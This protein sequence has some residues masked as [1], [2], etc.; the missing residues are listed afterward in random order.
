LRGGILIDEVE[1]KGLYSAEAG[2]VMQRA[3]RIGKVNVR[4][5]KRSLGRGTAE[6]RM[7]E[8]LRGGSLTD[9]TAID[10]S[11]RQFG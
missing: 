8:G 5:V 11:L 2:R 3:A 7:G 4:F 6:R 10:A 9:G 1:E